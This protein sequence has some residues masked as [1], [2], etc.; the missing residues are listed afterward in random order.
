M[1]T[2]KA[3][4]PTCGDVDLTPDDMRVTVAEEAGWSTYSFTCKTCAEPVTKP[5]DDEIVRLLT[6]AGVRVRTVHVPGEFLQSQLLNRTRPPLTE[7]DL[8]DFA[9]WLGRDV[10]VISAAGS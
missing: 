1:T 2:I 6:G 7:D 3:T 9:L 5:A 10:D 4:C 8:L